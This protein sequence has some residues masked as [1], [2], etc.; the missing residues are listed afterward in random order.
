IDVSSLIRGEEPLEKVGERIFQKLVKVAN[1]EL[2]KAE[3]LGYGSIAVWNIGL[4][5]G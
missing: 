2:T 5:C 1:G 3:M 4:L